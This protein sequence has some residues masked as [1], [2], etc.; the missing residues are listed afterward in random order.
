MH[1]IRFSVYIRQKKSK[2]MKDRAN[3]RAHVNQQQLHAI[4]SLFVSCKRWFHNHLTCASAQHI[5]RTKKNKEKKNEMNIKSG[6]KI[7]MDANV[8]GETHKFYTIFLLLRNQNSIISMRT[9]LLHAF[10][11]WNSVASCF[12]FNSQFTAISFF[13]LL[14]VSFFFGNHR[15]RQHSSVEMKGKK[16]PDRFISKPAIKSTKAFIWAT[17]TL[18]KINWQNESEQDADEKRA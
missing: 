1:P 5:L 3:E 17:S 16:R 4:D 11:I 8:H 15:T 18:S 9:L 12:V 2:W 14:V 6:I 10:G 13:F 7:T